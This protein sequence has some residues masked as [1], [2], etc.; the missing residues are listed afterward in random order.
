MCLRKRERPQ[1][2]TICGFGFRLCRFIVDVSVRNRDSDCLGGYWA[3]LSLLKLMAASCEHIDEC[4]YHLIVF[5]IQN[6]QNRESRALHLKLDEVIRALRPAHNEMI[7]IE[8]LSDAE[9]EEL[10]RHYERI[11]IE[12]QNRT[13]RRA[14]SDGDTSDS[15]KSTACGRAHDQSV[16]VWHRYPVQWHLVSM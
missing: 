3:V 15:E 8:K 13:R 2:F 14:T 10:A 1:F 12:S 9:L 6:T 11:R 7:N 16:A 4:C 5:L